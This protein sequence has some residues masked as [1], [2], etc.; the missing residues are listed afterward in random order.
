M[1]SRNE[2]AGMHGGRFR[3]RIIGSF[4]LGCF[5]A[6]VT[7]WAQAVSTSQLKGT[8]QDPSGSV[9]PGAEVTVTQT[10]TGVART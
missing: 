1:I 6:C 3:M 5:F 2:H 10:D 8:V 4:L 9:V 7:L